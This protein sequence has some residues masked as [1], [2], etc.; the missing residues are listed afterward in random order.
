MRLKTVANA[1]HLESGIITAI[2]IRQ[3]RRDQHKCASQG[4]IEEQEQEDERLRNKVA[5]T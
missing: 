5:K 3:E 4:D 1:V 2:G